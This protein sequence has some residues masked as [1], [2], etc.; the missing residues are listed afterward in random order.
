MVNEPLV[1]E[2]LR[3][4]WI[5]L[6]SR[7]KRRHQSDCASAV[8]LSWR[9]LTSLAIETIRTDL[10]MLI[11]IRWAHIYLVVFFSRW[12]LYS[13]LFPRHNWFHK[14]CTSVS[15]SVYEYPNWKDQYCIAEIYGK[16][17]F[18]DRGNEQHIHVQK[19]S[20]VSIWIACI[21]FTVHICRH[22]IIK[23]M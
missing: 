2:W 12:G 4:D 1:F 6:D 14:E 9:S 10:R 16:F 8:L 13:L 19:W 5:P 11:C 20:T 17:S 7:V 3:F 21:F 18:P 15:H 22:L 23:E